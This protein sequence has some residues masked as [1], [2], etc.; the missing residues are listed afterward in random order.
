MSLSLATFE[1]ATIF[2][3]GVLYG[4]GCATLLTVIT[5]GANRRRTTQHVEAQ[6]VQGY[7][8]C[9]KDRAEQPI[10]F[11][12]VNPPMTGADSPHWEERI[13]HR[14]EELRTTG[15]LERAERDRRAANGQIAITP[16]VSAT[17]IMV[18]PI[19]PISP[20]PKHRRPSQSPLART[21]VSMTATATGWQ[22][23]STEVM[24]AT[25]VLHLNEH[26]AS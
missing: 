11:P 20:P 6:F 3:S 10:T 14:M 23:S 5:V 18:K 4:G 7:L 12:S 13:A 24:T 2:I 19:L 8:A 25:D 9:L 22:T 1:A 16:G 17:A 15:E 26:Q 21:T